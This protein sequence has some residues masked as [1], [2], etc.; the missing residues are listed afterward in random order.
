MDELRKATYSGNAEA[1]FELGQIYE[2]KKNSRRSKYWYEK[3]CLQNHAE[4]CIA[5]ANFYSSKPH[6]N[7]KKEL[8]LLQKAYSFG[9]PIAADNLALYYK[10]KGNYKAFKK[11]LDR[12]LMKLPNNGE[13][14]FELA[15]YY[16]EGLGGRKAYKKSYKLFIKALGTKDISFFTRE[17]FFF[18]IGK[19]YFSGY[20]VKKSLRKAKYLF[21]QANIDN[22]H[23]DVNNFISENARILIDIK[24]Q[25]VTL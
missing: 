12:S 13:A 17:E 16:Y 23:P 22:D 8:I 5:L 14:L 4:S 9:S 11:W 1:Q 18:I 19:M 24:K 7:S 3:A 2:T 15:K 25:K 6:R 10:N 20:G 21:Y